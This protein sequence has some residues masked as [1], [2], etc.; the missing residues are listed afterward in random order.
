MSEVTQ[1]LKQIEQGHAEAA[2]D[3]LPLVYE[4]LRKLAAFRLASENPGHTLQATALV[5]D[6][7]LRLV[8]V[9]QVQKWDSRGHFF[10]AAAESM[11]RILINRARDKKRLKR[12]GGR[13]RVELDDVAVALGYPR[14]GATG[15]GRS[16][17]GTRRGRS[18]GCQA[19]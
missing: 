4:E 18:G 11:R 17:A 15:S 5:H 6:A 12:G 3:L 8:D 7:Y 10:A 13:K 16:N 14:R 1:I 2:E 19:G 9:E